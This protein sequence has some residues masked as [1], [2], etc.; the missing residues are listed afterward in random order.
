MSQLYLCAQNLL[1]LTQNI[2]TAA[3]HFY[4]C[5]NYVCVYKTI[6]HM[7]NIFLQLQKYL[8]HILHIQNINDHDY[9]PRFHLLI[10]RCEML[11]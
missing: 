2:S 1:T 11:S 3:K 9:I 5:A 10:N 7:H 6:S 8:L 4:T